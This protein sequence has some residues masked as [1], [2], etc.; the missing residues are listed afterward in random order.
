M[1]KLVLTFVILCFST[2]ALAADPVAPAT[3]DTK[4]EYIQMHTQMASAHQKAAE[5]LTAGKPETEC[6]SAF[7]EACEKTG[8]PEKCGA[9]MRHRKMRR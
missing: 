9:G 4:Q 7:H 3:A 8:G 2:S 1:E 6:R 5:C